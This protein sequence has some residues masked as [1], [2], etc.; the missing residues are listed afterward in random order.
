MILVRPGR[1][2]RLGGG[3]NQ[4]EQNAEFSD[5]ISH[6]HPDPP[7]SR[8]RESIFEHEYFQ[9]RLCTSGQFPEKQAIPMNN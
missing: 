1:E 9:G 4:T 8:G 6:P 5:N 2:Y 3:G 7:P